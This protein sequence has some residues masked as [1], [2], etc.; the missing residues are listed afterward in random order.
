MLS[1]RT[2]LAIVF[3][4]SK[5]S[6]GIGVDQKYSLEWLF[7]QEKATIHNAQKACVNSETALSVREQRWV[8][9]MANLA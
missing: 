2:D 7:R 4:K 5:G 1:N 6:F 9:S 8:P 3:R